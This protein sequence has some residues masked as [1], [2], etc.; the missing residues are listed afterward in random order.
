M[1]KTEKISPNKRSLIIAFVAL[2]GVL[3]TCWLGEWQLSR[4]NE[5]LQLMARLEEQMSLPPL[6]QSELLS[7][8]YS[9]K[10]M[11]RRVELMG[12]W[13]PELTI[14]LA[15]RSH[16]G[17]SGFWVMTPL[18]LNV[19]TVV[20]VQRGWVAWNPTNPS[21]IPDQVQTPVGLV[22]IEGLIV[23]T[24]SKMLELWGGTKADEITDKKTYKKS[25]V[26][27]NFDLDKFENQT[28]LKISAV[29]HQTAEPS[30]GLMRDLPAQGVSSDRNFGYSVQWFLLSALIAA[31]YF[32]FQWIKPYL[33][34]RRT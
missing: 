22:K 20:L 25:D 16:E 34:A 33:H 29:I 8:T 4:G 24:P 6:T 18:K 9:W 17:K 21:L 19:Q 23:G 31:L 7:A 1:D 2:A 13:L 28:Q 3:I 26:W 5:K 27:Q 32:W 11:N 30:E 15:N 10:S 14:Y 12:E